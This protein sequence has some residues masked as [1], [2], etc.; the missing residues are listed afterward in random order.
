ME[1]K[2]KLP[3]QKDNSEEIKEIIKEKERIK[4]LK[5]YE[6]TWEEVWHT[7]YE[8]HTGKHKKGIFEMSLS[9]PDKARLLEVKTAIENGE[10][11]SYVESLRDFNKAHALRLYNRLDQLRRENTIKKMIDQKPANYI[12]VQSQEQFE[13]LVADLLKESI[14]AVD[15]ETTG[16]DIFEDVIVG[17]SFTLPI[18]DYHVYI[19]V[20]HTVGKQLPREW[21]LEGLRGVLESSTIK[22]VLHNAKYDIH[23]FRRH[24]IRLNGVVHDTMIAMAILNENEPSFALKNLA[25]KYGRYF[26][27][28][29]K[30]ATY[31]ELFG[32]DGFENT[33]LDIGT[34]YAAKDTHLTWQFY[35][36][37]MEQFARLPEL[38]K[39]YTTIEN[40]VL[41]VSVEMEQNGFLVDLEYAKRYEKELSEQIQEIEEK[42]KTWFGDTNLNS[43]S[44]LQEVLYDRLGLPD[45]SKKRS[46]D[47][48]TL[49]AL[50]YKHE[51]I[52]LLLEYRELTK[53]LGTYVEALPRLVAKDGRLHGQFNQVATV[54]GRFASRNPNLQNL[55]SQARK[56]IKAP[57][58]KVIVGIDYS[59]IEPRVLAHLSGDEELMRPYLEGTDLYSTL[60]ARVFNK[61]IEECGDGSKW[62]KMMKTGLLATMYGTSMF[63]LSEQLGIS[64]PEAEK[65][66]ADFMAAYPK[67]AQFIKDT[68]A[69]VE[70]KEYV[71]T[72]F[73][74]KRRFPGHKHVAVQY[75]RLHS[76]IVK[77]L[78]REFSNIW[79]E[80]LPYD[81]KRKYW[82]VAKKYHTVCRQ[83]VNARIQG[84][85]ADIMKLALI[86]VEKYCSKKGWKVLATVHDEILFEIDENI[87]LDEVNELERLM[88]SVVS[89]S[90]PLKV[91][92][93]FMRR[94]GEETPKKTWFEVD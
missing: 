45:I 80:S 73:G 66:I 93:A 83:S 20:G 49:K 22:K 85:A 67:V 14:I 29:D 68:H 87:S 89:L 46:T 51:S 8:L 4:R 61:P 12:C 17:I 70:E 40:P 13:K 6:P 90:I 7:G 43:P 88:T 38:Y 19:P 28:E 57:T 31:E 59:Q 62:R 36:W 10:I 44:Q 11:P 82:D 79:E 30:S 74:R 71:T 75:K 26:G 60:A 5:N 52:P 23:M 53:L 64:V 9:E 47:A 65:F 54:T 3:K 55:P 24:G 37:Q 76:E 34:I 18:A 48:K 63:T 39:V 21:V 33:P 27:F 77:R 35:K 86:E 81:L 2:I 78:G 50:Q 41:S 15:T 25:T 91:D 69:K 42:I 16:L 72:L 58:G 56:M 84:T 94:W 1:L 32:K 92:T